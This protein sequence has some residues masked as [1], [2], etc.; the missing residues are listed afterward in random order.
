MNQLNSIQSSLDTQRKRNKSLKQEKSYYEQAKRRKSVFVDQIDSH[1]SNQIIKNY[2]S[3]LPQIKKNQ[4]NSDGQDVSIILNHFKLY[5]QQNVKPN[6]WNQFFASIWDFIQKNGDIYDLY[7]ELFKKLLFLQFQQLQKQILD[8]CYQEKILITLGYELQQDQLFNQLFSQFVQNYQL[9]LQELFSKGKFN[10][11]QLQDV[12]SLIQ[13]NNIIEYVNIDVQSEKF[14]QGNSTIWMINRK[15]NQTQQYKLNLKI[16]RRYFALWL[17]EARNLE[18]IK[19]LPRQL[20]TASHPFIN[21]K[22]SQPILIVDLDE[23]LVHFDQASNRLMIRNGSQQFLQ[24]MHKYYY[25]IIWTA[26]LP[27]YAKWALK[28][29]DQQIHQYIDVLLTREYC[30]PHEKGFYQKILSMLGQELSLLLIIENDYRSV[31]DSE[32]DHLHLID[33]YLGQDDNVLFDLSNRLIDAYKFYQDGFSLQRAF[34]MTSI[35][36]N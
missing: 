16:I 15:C 4:V 26:S 18:I 28:K 34:K 9:C 6:N 31:I 17:H 27:R 3:F 35:K 11:K 24:Q 23:T 8:L 36:Q 5:Q 25:V 10:K 33:S 1:S 21:A 32:K 2:K 30:I 29:I 14:Q 19:V 12:Q 13:M 20:L 7:Q 22:L